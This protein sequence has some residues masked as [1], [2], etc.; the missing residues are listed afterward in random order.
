V[1]SKP[2]SVSRKCHLSHTMRRCGLP[3]SSVRKY[4]LGV[5]QLK[6]EELESAKA[7]QVDGSS[8]PPTK[9][10]ARKKL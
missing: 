8:L 4:I 2:I 10:V 6:L 1:V 3:I 5:S 7:A 9:A